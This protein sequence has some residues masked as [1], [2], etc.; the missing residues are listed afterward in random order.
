M[1]KIKIKFLGIAN[2]KRFYYGDGLSCDTKRKDTCF[3]EVSPEKAAQL[4]VDYPNEWEYITRKGAEIIGKQITEYSNKIVA[5]VSST[6]GV[7]IIE[8]NGN[9]TKVKPIEKPKAEPKPIKKPAK[10]INKPK[11][12][13]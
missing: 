5:Q 13:V 11:E 8:T 12:K 2:M 6:K 7:V 4:M 10:K 1:S 9:K 3:V